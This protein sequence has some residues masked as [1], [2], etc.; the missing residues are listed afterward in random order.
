[1]FNKVNNLRSLQKKKKKK[2]KNLTKEPWKLMTCL[3]PVDNCQLLE[4]RN[5]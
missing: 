4:N 3:R 5:V 1:M 2:I